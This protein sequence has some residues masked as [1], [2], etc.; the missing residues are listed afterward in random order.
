MTGRLRRVQ[1][2]DAGS[3]YREMQHSGKS[4]NATF[5]ECSNLH[6]AHAHVQDTRTREYVK[7]TTE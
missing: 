1:Q 3:Y 5:A 4:G 6:K 2:R 7:V